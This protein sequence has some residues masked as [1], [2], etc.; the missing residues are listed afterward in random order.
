[1]FQ[2]TDSAFDRNKRDL[3]SSLA[4]GV[5]FSPK[6]SIDLPVRDFVHLINLHSNYVT[7][8]SCS[9]RISIYESGEAT[10]GIKWLLVKHE[11]IS[12]SD[13]VGAVV[14]ADPAAGLVML[15]CEPFIL[16][17][18]CRDLESARELYQLAFSCGYRE[19]GISVGQKKV[20]VALRTTAFGLELPIADGNK[21]LLN[22]DVVDIIVKEANNRLLKNFSRI[23]RLLK[24]IKH[25]WK[26][27]KL[28]LVS[29]LDNSHFRRF[30][31]VCWTHTSA[32]EVDESSL[33]VT[34]GN[35]CGDICPKGDHGLLNNTR[36][37]PTS[38]ARFGPA[39]VTKCIEEINNIDD[40][41]HAAVCTWQVS[42]A[43]TLAVV[44]GGRQGLGAPLHCCHIFRSDATG[45]VATAEVVDGVTGQVVVPEPRWGHSLTKL[46]S[47]NS[48]SG[49][50]FMFGG[51]NQTTLFDDAFLLVVNLTTTA[52]TSDDNLVTVQW[53]RVHI[54]GDVKPTARCFHAGSALSVYCSGTPGAELSLQPSLL[55]DVKHAGVLLHGGLTSLTNPS[56]CGY[57]Y[58]VFPVLGTCAYVTSSAESVPTTVAATDG[59]GANSSESEGFFGSGARLFLRKFGHTISN[60]GGKSFLVVGGNSFGEELGLTVSDDQSGIDCRSV[61]VDLM[62]NDVGDLMG[63]FR[64]V[65][66]ADSD[67]GDTLPCGACRVHHCAVFDA[68][69]QLLKLIGGGGLCLSFGAHFCESVVIHC[70][71]PV[72]TSL[73]SASA[74]SVL[75]HSCPAFEPRASVRA[76]STA[77][78]DRAQAD[79]AVVLLV[80]PGKVKCLKS[81]FEE[82]KCL[83]KLKRISNVDDSVGNIFLYDLI[84]GMQL[85]A[86]DDTDNMI[87]NVN[88]SF[89]AIPVTKEFGDIL[90]TT[91]LA[92][93]PRDPMIV[94]YAPIL[95]RMSELLQSNTVLV[96]RQSVRDNKLLAVSGSKH[97]A[98]FLKEF[99]YRNNFPVKCIPTK[100]ELV[101]DVLM[102]PEDAL[103]VAGWTKYTE[104]PTDGDITSVNQHQIVNFWEQLAAYF[105]VQRVARKAIIDSGEM[106]ESKVR[107]LL[108]RIGSGRASETGPGTVGWVQVTENGIKFGFDITRVMFC[109]GNVTER[110][111]M[112]RQATEG[113]IIVDLYCGVGYY[114][115]PFLVHGKAK[116]VHACEWNPNSL[117]A[118]RHNL[119]T[120]KVDASR[121]T[122]Y[123]GDNNIS[124]HQFMKDVADRV[125]L[126]LLPSSTKGWPLAA[127]V[128][129]P[130]GGILH[131]HEN[132]LQ[133]EIASWSQETA[134]KFEVLLAEAS[135]PM[136]VSV[137]HVEIVKNY[138]PRVVHVVLD[139]LCSPNS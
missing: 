138:A 27:P 95:Q 86:A 49:M 75:P 70:T 36:K 98:D 120:A 139:L 47:D 114:S 5:D 134:A 9:G 58:V 110:M 30:G 44:S 128:L 13:V 41:V 72:T 105:N 37:A 73:N 124:A 76:A 16:H 42:A 56:T 91:K 7:T 126:G 14:A 94:K 78:V 136:H 112:G 129:K 64:P 88:S 38:I 60:V 24:N 25:A 104:I 65:D 33:V 87:K 115:I 93:T 54:T 92:P 21:L 137:N 32:T 90:T 68:K 12:K 97:A 96:G 118:I 4:A 132:I 127:H 116:H 39:H 17:V 61:V 23:D 18:H 77:S 107:L 20:M 106:R 45:E 122:I 109:S 6:G 48:S 28:S 85:S 35:S 84:L 69:H 43:L 1:M 99:A 11:T 19:S 51:R 15:K 55:D 40:R 111:R 103:N 113:Q 59:I 62:L 22:G 119:V 135:K 34:G 82:S 57:F 53:I 83:E 79:P 8:S 130:T 133:A 46:S 89:L 108:P 102:I 125:C 52:D 123:E 80:H 50:F 26:W 31:H 3:L 71:L 29:V 2:H 131:V 74:T 121:Y 10:K 81:Y 117:L 101:G 100:F 67:L 66:I 63:S